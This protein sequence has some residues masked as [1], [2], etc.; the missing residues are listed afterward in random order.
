[1]G[2]ISEIYQKSVALKSDIGRQ[3]FLTSS[4]NQSI[5][6]S[7]FTV[8]LSPASLSISF[9]ISAFMGSLCV[10]SPNAI[11]ELLNGCPSTLP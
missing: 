9:R 4:C 5:R 3:S 7:N 10:P 2:R 8:T 11:N 6:S 1:M